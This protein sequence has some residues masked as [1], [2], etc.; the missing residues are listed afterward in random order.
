MEPWVVTILVAIIGALGVVGAS[1][2]GPLIKTKI[3][4]A[5]NKKAIVKNINTTE[6]G[7]FPD[8]PSW[9]D[10]FFTV[11]GGQT[12]V[13]HYKLQR[14]MS[15]DEWKRISGGLPDENPEIQTTDVTGG[16][17]ARALGKIYGQRVSDLVDGYVDGV[18]GKTPRQV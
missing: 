18:F 5:K 17:S 1:M 2:V 16:Q 8:I 14:W 9:E 3:T 15:P 6:G 4:S 11:Y 12:Y 10:A 13:W 7:E